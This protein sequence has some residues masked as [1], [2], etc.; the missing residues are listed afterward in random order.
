MSE[1]KNCLSRL[2]VLSALLASILI[3]WLVGLFIVARG[4]VVFHDHVADLAT[5]L[6]TEHRKANLMGAITA[7]AGIDP[8]L[9]ATAQGLLPPDNPAVKAKMSYL[10]NKLEL[11]NMI[12][13]ATDGEVKAYMVKNVSTS[14]TGKNFAWRPYF[15]GAI[16][17]KP[18]MYAAF[19]SNSHERGFYISVPIPARADAADLVSPIG[20]L[21]AKLGFEEI[22]ALLAYEKHP[23][24][25]L[26]PEGVVF[27]SNKKEWLYQVLGG[28]KELLHAQE[29]KRV[30]NAY[31]ET[32][33]KLIPLDD[34]K[35]T[36]NNQKLKLFTA[37]IDW[38]DPSGS[39]RVAGF[40]SAKDIFGWQT[41]MVTATATFLLL[42]LFYALLRSRQLV[43][44]KTEQVISL[45][46]NS[47]E[48]FL[49][50]TRDLLVDS[51]YSRAC[52]QML[53]TDPGGR[54]VA[55]LLFEDSTDAAKLMREIINAVQVEKDLDVQQSMLSLLP[56]EI[57]RSNRLLS[58]EYR[59]INTEKFMVILSDITEQHRIAQQLETEQKHLKF[60]V[61]AV[62]DSRSFFEILDAF[63]QFITQWQK[64]TLADDDPYRSV[65]TAYREIH[66]FKGLLGQFS[67]PHTP[68]LLHQVES[69]LLNLLAKD[70]TAIANHEIIACI[71][72]ARLQAAFDA[73][74]KILTAEL[75]DEFLTQG[76]TMV[77][78]D[79]QAR[80]LEA[81]SRCILSGKP[82]DNNIP[83]LRR[84]L[85]EI[86]RLRK[87]CLADLLHGFQRLMDQLAV[88]TEKQLAPLL[89]QGGENIWLDPQ[90]YRPFLQSLVHIFRN[91]VIHG[92][93]NAEVRWEKDKDENGQ[94][95][96]HL[97]NDKDNIYLT[98]A[99]DGAGLD[100]AVLRAK[101]LAQGLSGSFEQDDEAAAGLVFLD[102]LS[103][104][105]ETSDLAGRGVGLAA[106][107]SEVEK[108]GGS[109]AVYTKPD[110]GTEFRFI[111]P[112]MHQGEYSL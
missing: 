47:G 5:Q 88:R 112:I 28:E 85:H 48:G 61:L 101:A 109:V 63:R 84:L 41:R 68:Q 29:A 46:D 6:A 43:H 56:R 11:D 53:G 95:S 37:P 91:A 30:N 64:N 3:T 17:G 40:I 57:K 70:K 42:L 81:L 25:V 38:P 36:I 82:V 87:L 54:E 50:F 27:A 94:I 72:P 10:F 99:D 76:Y 77:L 110:Q 20:V 93:E 96:C 74:L 8:D 19:G 15:F 65:R 89:V 73:D 90:I 52:E 39:W 78:T 86:I 79:S 71:Q 67:F 104:Q 45:L 111:I 22:D 100:L 105:I 55:E 107:K 106:V 108:L 13:M 21:V 49:S 62:S 103:T 14:I 60:I 51:E 16:A 4:Q 18:T 75:G 7:F 83:D 34:D 69:C 97:H 9:R 66:T 44:R 23:L 32:P 59:R 1:M 80:Q 102:R 35:I 31:K 12:V 33:P 2:V 26:S 24:M 98:I 58:V 92:I